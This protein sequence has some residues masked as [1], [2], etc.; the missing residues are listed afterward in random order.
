MRLLLYFP[1]SADST[2]LSRAQAEFVD[3]LKETT[4][5]VSIRVCR[6]SPARCEP[7]SPDG[8][9]VCWAVLRTKMPRWTSRST[10]RLGTRV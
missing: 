7:D 2:A 6:D 5:L 3:V 1:F 4:N 8:P 9:I 10:R